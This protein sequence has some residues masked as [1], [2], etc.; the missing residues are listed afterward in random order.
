MLCQS[1]TPDLFRGPGICRTAPEG[2]AG[3]R[4][5]GTAAVCIRTAIS[6][7]NLILQ[8]KVDSMLSFNA[9]I[10]DDF[11]GIASRICLIFIAG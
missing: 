8:L 4:A 5:L 9:L 2:E 6:E 7:R 1:K 11:L 10:D 3:R